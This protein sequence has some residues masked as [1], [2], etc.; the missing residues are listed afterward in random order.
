MT[1]LWL[2][3]FQHLLPNGRAWRI[4]HEKTLREYFKGLSGL[5]EDVKAYFDA[6]FN[7]LDPY[8]TRAL[9]EWEDQFGFTRSLLTDAQ[10]RA[11]LDAAW[12]STGGQSPRYIQDALQS[13]GFD[14][15]VHDWWVPDTDPPVARDPREVLHDGGE[16]AYEMQDAAPDAQDGDPKAQDG[17]RLQPIGYPLVNKLYELVG[18]EIERIDYATPS[19]PDLWPYFFYIGGEVY[20]EG[21]SVPQSRRDEF[22][23]LCLKICPAQLWLGLIVTYS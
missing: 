2:R 18:G 3:V 13:A 5:P 11:R 6:I 16:L 10:R 19:D 14:V 4:T 1:S 21:A 7:D 8:K 23:D 9:E 17:G 20:G 15:Y 12:K 22:E